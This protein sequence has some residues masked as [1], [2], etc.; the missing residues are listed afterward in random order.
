M[1]YRPVTWWTGGESNSRPHAC[2]ACA[3]PTELSARNL[4]ISDHVCF[5]FASR[6]C[7]PFQNLL[8]LIPLNP[9]WAVTISQ[10]TTAE[11]AAALIRLLGINV[12]LHRVIQ[13]WGGM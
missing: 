2:D 7:C 3:L 5:A 1:S 13:T 6:Q 4:V 12:N 9:N 11:M 10:S 8:H